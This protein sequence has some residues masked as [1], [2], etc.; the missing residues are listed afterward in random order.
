MSAASEYAIETHANCP[1]TPVAGWS[2]DRDI[3]RGET[4]KELSTSSFSPG[5][6]AAT[7]TLQVR[8]QPTWLAGAQSIQ[9]PIIVGTASLRSASR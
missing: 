7:E 5:A 8:Y 6:C 2:I 1:N 4:V 3:K 9:R